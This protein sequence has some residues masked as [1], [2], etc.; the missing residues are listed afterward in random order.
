MQLGAWNK[1]TDFAIMIT[2]S[3][4]AIYEVYSDRTMS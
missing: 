2:I 3:I 1:F 4:N